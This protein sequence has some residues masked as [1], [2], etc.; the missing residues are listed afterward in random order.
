MF[1]KLSIS[2]PFRN[3]ESHPGFYSFIDKWLDQTFKNDN[4]KK[5]LF[6]ADRSLCKSRRKLSVC[7]R[8]LKGQKLQADNGALDAA[9]NSNGILFI[10][11]SKNLEATAIR[12]RN[13]I[14]K[15]SQPSPISI[16]I[17]TNKLDEDE[18]Q[19]AE[20]LAPSF[21]GNPMISDYEIVFYYETSLKN[22]NL[23]ETMIESLLFLHKNHLTRINEFEGLYDLEMQ[24]TTDF[25]SICLGEELWH[26][27]GLSLKQNE[28]FAR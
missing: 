18:Q 23:S 11:T 10:A 26:R 20:K 16:I 25:L 24:S 6:L 21:L 5:V 17:Y 12:L 7:L 9:D 15:L 27:V 14:A 22:K 8:K 3:E 28:A 4:E 13:A 2:I 1:W 19:A